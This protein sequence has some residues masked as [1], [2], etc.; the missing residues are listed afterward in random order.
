MVQSFFQ[1][2]LF[3]QVVTRAGVIAVTVVLKSPSPVYG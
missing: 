1:A 3:T 2:G